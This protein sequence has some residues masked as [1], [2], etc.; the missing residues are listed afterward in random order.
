MPL[1]LAEELW[2]DINAF[3][4]HAQKVTLEHRG[5]SAMQNRKSYAFRSPIYLFILD[6]QPKV[7]G[8]GLCWTVSHLCFI[9]I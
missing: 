2:W 5:H 4:L 3:L 7:Q 9:R 1:C 6:L 8:A